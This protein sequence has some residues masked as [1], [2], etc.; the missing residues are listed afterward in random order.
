M[1]TTAALFM[2]AA[3]AVYTCNLG[4]TRIYRLSDGVLA[5]LSVDHVQKSSLFRNAPL[6][7][8]LGVPSSEMQIEPAMT[9]A[10]YKRGDRYLICSDGVWRTADKNMLEKILNTQEDCAK[11]LQR[12]RSWV[13]DNDGTDNATA[14]LVYLL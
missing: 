14:I 13:A 8:Y 1:G 4:D 7:Q 10:E 3:D 11:C 5:Q 6:T 12:L 9:S 2:A